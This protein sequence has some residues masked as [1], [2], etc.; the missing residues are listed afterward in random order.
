MLAAVPHSA[1]CGAGS[2]GAKGRAGGRCVLRIG[3]PL[4]SWLG[5]G[6]VL[7]PRACQRLLP[8]SQSGC[9]PGPARVCERLRERLVWSPRGDPQV[10][11]S[12]R[13]VGP[14]ALARS[15]ALLMA[16]SSLPAHLLVV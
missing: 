2:G 8:C 10:V 5:E 3:S 1:G 7:P 11:T 4:P 12:Q 9:G 16:V 13:V 15:G 14:D 6:Q